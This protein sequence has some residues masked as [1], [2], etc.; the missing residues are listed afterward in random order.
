MEFRSESQFV[1]DEVTSY[2]DRA[3]RE[4]RDGILIMASFY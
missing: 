4:Q 2:A 3:N 1:K